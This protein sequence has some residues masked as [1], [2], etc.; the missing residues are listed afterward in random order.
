[1]SGKIEDAATLIIRDICEYEPDDNPDCVVI[2]VKALELILLQRLEDLAAP[3]VERQGVA[4]YISRESFED[5]ACVGMHGTK[6]PTPVQDM[7]LFTSPPAP[8]A[9]PVEIHQMLIEMRQ[10]FE[11]ANFVALGKLL[12]AC[13]DKVKELNQ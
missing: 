3:V 7:P 2:S 1:M 6:Y 12:T 8:V 5:E 11:R 13:L 4:L 10:T 9:V